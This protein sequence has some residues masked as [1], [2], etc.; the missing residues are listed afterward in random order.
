MRRSWQELIRKDIKEQ[1]INRVVVASCS[2]RMHEPTFRKVCESV[3]L[4]GYFFEMANIREHVSWCTEDREAATEKA[5]ALVAA[6]VA[7][8]PLQ[9]PLYERYA[10]MNDRVLVIG[11]GIAGIEAALKVSGGNKR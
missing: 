1:G 11:G 7:R 8:V 3:G 2:P 9:E 5:K 10:D 6:A 4:N